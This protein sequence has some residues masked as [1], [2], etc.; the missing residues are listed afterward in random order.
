MGACTL[1]ATIDDAPASYE[2]DVDVLEQ[3][4][5]LAT[6]VLFE[7][8]RR[9]WPGTCHDEFRPMAQFR[10]AP[11][12]RWWPD[13][14]RGSAGWCSCNRVRETGCARLPEIKL[15]GTPVIL[16]SVKVTLDGAAFTDF[17]LHDHRYLVR[18][19]GEGWPCC[20]DLLAPLTDEHMGHR[21]RLR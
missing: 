20:Q 16:D 9:R 21:V 1:W 12:P 10:S 11:D 8:T 13:E 14:Q 5:P 19:D 3:V 2:G 4:L 6:D 7:L 15:P 18:T 17:A